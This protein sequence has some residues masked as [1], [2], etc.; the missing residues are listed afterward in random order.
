M[1]PLKF[2]LIQNHGEWP[3]VAIGLLQA[4]L[5]KGLETPEIG[6]AL[7]SPG[8]GVL[9]RRGETPGRVMAEVGLGGGGTAERPRRAA[10]DTGGVEGG[11]P[12]EPVSPGFW[13]SASRTAGEAV[14]VV[15]SRSASG[16]HHS[17]CRKRACLPARWSPCQ[18][19]AVRAQPH[20]QT[21]TVLCRHPAD[22]GRWKGG[23]SAPSFPGSPGHRARCPAQH[24]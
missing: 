1:P 17:S 9:L 13:I 15:L 7:L 21:R 20:T 8:A 23:P 12:P 2:M 3:V 5:V 24:P 16:F 19:C 14:F 22:G 4:W 10:P 18:P 11:L 6:W